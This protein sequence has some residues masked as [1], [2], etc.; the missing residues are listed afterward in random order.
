MPNTVTGIGR[1]G[2]GFSR[3]Y[4]T[5]PAC[6]PSRTSL[7]TGR[8]AHNH[9]VLTNALKGGGYRAFRSHPAF[10]SNLAPWLQRAG[11]RT[12]HIGKFLNWYGEGDARE[13]PPG[14]DVWETTVGENEPDPYYSYQLNVDGT[15]RRGF[16]QNSGCP[17]NDATR[18]C[19]YITDQ[20][21]AR[22]L[23]AIN[24]AGRRPF[25]LQL[26]YTAP[27]GDLVA[28]GGTGAARPPFAALPGF[29]GEA[30]AVL[31]RARSL[32]QAELCPAPAVDD[33][34]APRPADEAGAES[35]ARPARGR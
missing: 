30:R 16:Q 11:Y 20:I 22:G 29:P 8:Y 31:Q 15:I 35:A 5:T 34:G 14:W 21:T 9:R 23:A 24:R 27:H 10:E 32:R 25:Y 7:L 18:A 33:P 17:A 6:C 26:D 4:A 2:V 1:K 12:V 28:P 3:Y 13:V 19:H